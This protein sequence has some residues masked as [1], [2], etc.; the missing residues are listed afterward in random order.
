M[1]CLP[2]QAL[3]I[4]RLFRLGQLGGV[5]PWDDCLIVEQ[6]LR[7]LELVSLSPTLGR[8]LHMFRVLGPHSAVADGQAF[9]GLALTGGQAAGAYAL[10]VVALMIALTAILFSLRKATLPLV[11]GLIALMVAQPIT[12]QSLLWIKADFKSG[13]LIAAALFVYYQSIVQRSRR[14]GLVASAL[15]G[16]A[17][18]CKL[19]AFYLP[20]VAVMVICLVF[21]AEFITQ[22][23]EPSA[24]SPLGF[25]RARLAQFAACVALAVVPF[26][27]FFAWS[28]VSSPSILSYIHDALNATWSDGLSYASRALHY[29]PA[30]NR[31]WG[32]LH[33][34][35]LLFA[36][37]ALVASRLDRSRGFASFLA[38]GLMIAAIFYLPLVAA[39]ASNFE[40]SGTFLGVILGLVMISFFSLAA[41]STA[42]GWAALLVVGAFALLTPLLSFALGDP[43]S[44][45][46]KR[47]DL[48][49]I[50]QTYR[51]ISAV[52]HAQKQGQAAHLLTFF[53]DEDAPYPNLSIFHFEGGG[54]TLFVQR[55]DDPETKGAADPRLAEADYLLSL[56][57]ADGVA[58]PGYHLSKQFGGARHLA[59]DNAFV[60]GLANFTVVRRYPW[61]GG[62]LRLYGRRGAA[63]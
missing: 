57:P 45:A 2:L 7:R 44:A 48:I 56:W 8:T 18:L 60:A 31:S 43:G 10:N 61:K 20:V 46:L 26:A 63:S 39:G 27:L 11:I 35:V 49:A 53:E 29:G 19:T 33:W 12:L 14:L 21:T 55:L 41:A 54:G 36:A 4:F 30:N 32:L 6:N 50:E 34:E 3:A 58:T 28:A 42:R 37:A 59:R 1:V 9:L 25:A 38:V 22:R 47:Q 40:F 5:L 16:G 51:Q 23:G 62:E 17:I 15:L 52:I 24:E 13:V